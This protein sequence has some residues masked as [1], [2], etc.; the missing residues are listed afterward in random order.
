MRLGLLL[1]SALA[2]TLPTVVGAVEPPCP[3][4]MRGNVRAGN[5]AFEYQSWYWKDADT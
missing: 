2:I 3:E 4:H 1:A 5:Y